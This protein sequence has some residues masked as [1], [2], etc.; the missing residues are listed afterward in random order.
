[1]DDFETHDVR[2]LLE[3][4]GFSVEPGIYLPGRLGV[5]SEV[6]AVLL[7]DGTEV[8]PRER[9]TDLIRPA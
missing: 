5:R 9:Q 6:N 1:L 3:G 7:A 4:V 8:T 2:D